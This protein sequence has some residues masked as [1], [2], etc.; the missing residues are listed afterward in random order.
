MGTI[1]YD[2]VMSPDGWRVRC[3]GMEGP[4]FSS[5]DEAIR[6]ALFAASE[7]AKSGEKVEVRMLEFDGPTKVWRSL[8]LRDAPR[9]RLP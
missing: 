9:P 3:K 4:A 8:E 1:R 7:L 6:D 5:S 2:I